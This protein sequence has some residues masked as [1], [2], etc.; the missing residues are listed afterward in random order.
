MQDWTTVRGSGANFVTQAT[1]DWL[2][3][4][5][6]QDVQFWIDV[7]EAV[8]TTSLSLSLETSPSVDEFMFQ[9]VIA[10]VP[11]VASSGPILPP[12]QALLAGALVPVAQWLRWR[13]LP[14]ASAWAVTFRIVISANSPGT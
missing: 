9:Q 2:D 14:G 4:T 3:V 6:Y 13:I 5:P 11:L 1:A 10:A 7:R 12:K 8:T